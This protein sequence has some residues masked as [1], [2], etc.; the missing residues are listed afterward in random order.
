MTRAL[1]RAFVQMFSLQ[2]IG[3]AVLCIV[4]AGALFAGLLFLI[5]FAIGFLPVL[6]WE[7]VNKVVQVVTGAGFLVLS[8]FLFQPV[9]V[10]FI[11]F[12]LEF[13]ADA[14]E[15]RYYPDELAPRSV[16]ILESV[17]ISLRFFATLVAVNLILLP[18]YFIPIING[19]VLILANGYLVGREYF[20]LVAI[21]HLDSDQLKKLRRQ[22]FIYLLGCGMFLSFLL[23]IPVV[24]FVA[25]LFGTAFMVHIYRGI[26]HNAE[27]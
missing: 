23:T 27:F 5:E 13:I 24:N 7:W 15:A 11:G 2:F 3:I 9:A 25:P 12:F 8:I 1:S 18:L 6:G 22:Q 4:A 19:L 17:I 20:E 26:R 21:R 10:L 14:V 16:P